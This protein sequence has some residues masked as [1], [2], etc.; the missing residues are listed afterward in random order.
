[1]TIISIF[2]IFK[3]NSIIKKYSIGS[4][5]SYLFVLFNYGSMIH[6]P[7]NFVC[8]KNSHYISRIIWS[9]ARCPRPNKNF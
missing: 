3:I 9:F 1:M 2:A 8:I 7:F 6:F 5:Y 4:S